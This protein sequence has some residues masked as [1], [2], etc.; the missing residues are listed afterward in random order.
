MTEDLK[1]AATDLIGID[2]GTSRIRAH[3]I[4]DDGRLLESREQD[5]GLDA[6]Q[7]DKFDAVLRSLVSGW[8]GKLPVLMCGMIGSRNGWNEAPYCRCPISIGDL[9]QSV[10]SVDSACG[11]VWIIGGAHTVDAQDHHDV[12]RGEETLMFGL[13][14]L[15]GGKLVVAPGTHSKWAL[16]EDATIK[17]FR[18]YMTGELYALLKQHSTLGWLMRETQRV[19][20]D[21]AAFMEGVQDAIAD[22]EI[23]HGLFNVRTSALF[24]PEKSR[25]LSSYLS[26]L[27]IGAEVSGAAKSQSSEAAFVIAAPRLAELYCLALSA[28][29]FRDVQ[30]VDANVAAARGLWRVWQ[31]RNGAA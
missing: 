9:S 22:P 27:L 25:T 16:M 2:W 31:T 10:I 20:S 14:R 28:V 18:T 7:K 12:M 4:G 17:H 6:V 29:G 1:M 30:V 24:R 19:D 11:D 13:A 8:S 15:E 3:R 23:L 21:Q 26:G 5:L